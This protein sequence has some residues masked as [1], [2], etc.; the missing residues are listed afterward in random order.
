MLFL[1]SD[2]IKWHFPNSGKYNNNKQQVQLNE[3]CIKKALKKGNR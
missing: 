2:K 1:K 3:G